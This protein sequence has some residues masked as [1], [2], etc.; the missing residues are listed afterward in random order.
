MAQDAPGVLAC[1]VFAAES[2][3]Q[4][5]PF[6]CRARVGLAPRGDIRMSDDVGKR[7]STTQ[8]ND[9]ANETF[10][11]DRLVADIICPFEFHP[12]GKVV[13]ALAPPPLRCPGMPGSAVAGHKLRQAP[14]PRYQKMS[15]NP[16][17]GHLPEIRVCIPIQ[18]IAEKGLDSAL[19]KLP[20]RQGYS[21]DDKQGDRFLFWP[22]IMIWR[23]PPH[24]PVDNSP[25]VDP[26][27]DWL[28]SS[29][30]GF[31]G[32]PSGNEGH[33]TLCPNALPRPSC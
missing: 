27:W 14:G 1:R 32:A 5:A 6:E 8:R 28:Q 16:E 21:M 29:P 3:F 2:R 9:Q 25:L 22:I 19:T 15:R 23:W 20:R 11:L 10:I 4:P 18:H 12:D 17:V 24:R 13:A 30:T 33:E 26:Q 7:V 31:Q